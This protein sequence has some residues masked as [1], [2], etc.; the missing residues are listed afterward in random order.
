ML[1]GNYLVA[2][3]TG[4]MGTTA[5]L[6]LKDQPNINVKAVYHNR[7]P[8]IFADNIEYI[9]ADLKDLNNCK[10]VVKD[11]DYVLMFAAILSTAP[12]VARDPVSHVT[13]TMIMN[14]QMLEA[15]YFEKIKKFIWLSSSTG[16]PM[17]DDILTEKD[18]FKGNPPDKYFSVGWMSRYTETLCRMYSTKLKEPIPIV[19]F[20][21]TT[22]YGEYESFDFK[23]SHVLPAL[24]RKVVEK[25]KPI[26]VWGNGEKRRD[27]I[28]SDDVFDAIILAMEKI[29]KY[30]VFNVGVGKDYSINEILK[31]ILE[32]DDFKD[33][34]IIFDKTKPTSIDKRTIDFSK[35]KKELSF[36]PKTT[37][38]DGI[39]KMINWYRQHPIK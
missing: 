3:S 13:E 36:K 7:K 27:L 6:R 32:I 1:P 16:Y 26:V 15:A 24:V 33:A 23:K 37:L 17:K 5:L 18:M 38:K 14:S 10:N 19:I 4:L 2:G 21:P 25:Q 31:T 34:E 12:M 22:I 28:Y 29:K 11:I 9:K 8:T 30:D 20:R 39:T 35:I